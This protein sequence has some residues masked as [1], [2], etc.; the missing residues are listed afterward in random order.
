MWLFLSAAH[1]E[2]YSAL[3]FHCAPLGVG[4]FLG[5]FVKLIKT[6][7]FPHLSLEAPSL[8]YAQEDISDKLRL[9]DVQL[10]C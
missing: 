2:S 6:T 3:P 8:A 1:E 10:D 4:V 5:I 9:R 7:L